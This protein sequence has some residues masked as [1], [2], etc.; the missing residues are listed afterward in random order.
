MAE[1]WLQNRLS[2]VKR[3][4]DRWVELAQ[5]IETFW[6]E[7]FDDYSERLD[8]L[9]SIFLA[10]RDDQLLIL[11]ELGKYYD[12]DLPD[13]N[14]PLAVIQRRMELFQKDT[15]VPLTESLKRA[16]PGIR[17]EWLPLYT[18]DFERYGELLFTE[19]DL[20][21]FNWWPAPSIHYLDGSWGVLSPTDICLT[22]N[23][24][25]SNTLPYM[26]S[27]AKLL[28]DESNIDNPEQ[29]ESTIRQRVSLVKPL[30]IVLHGVIWYVA[31]SVVV[32]NGDTTTSQLIRSWNVIPA[33]CCY[34]KVNGSW[35]LDGAT[36]LCANAGDLRYQYPVSSGP[37]VIRQNS[38]AY[39]DV[40][41]EL[42]SN[43]LDGSLFLDGTWSLDPYPS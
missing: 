4:T 42:F 34:L 12:I 3:D 2:P 35:L 23:S 29:I 38:I 24:S 21:K 20:H 31:L 9:K 16:C 27:R 6:Q 41:P 1:N 26:T 10:S 7:N 43:Y 32:E 14:I 40:M 39:C 28:I 25:A 30:H 5:A 19:R 37:M 11:S 8:S 13:N 15:L 18:F 17:T 36:Y 22:H 33:F